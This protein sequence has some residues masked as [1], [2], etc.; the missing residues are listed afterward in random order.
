MSGDHMKWCCRNAEC[1]R[2]NLMDKSIVEM[3]KA[4]NKRLLMVCGTCGYVYQFEEKDI[5]RGGSW[6]ECIPFREMERHL[7]TGTIS[8]GT[9]E[10]YQGESWSIN[11]FIERYGV[12]PE[13][14]LNWV[15][16]G[17]P[18]YSQTCD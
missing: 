15:K 16:A 6:L 12:D 1:K 7:P 11:D 13:L 2:I 17:K 18:K 8:N 10:D 14:Y 4:K 9:Y 3:A 5:A